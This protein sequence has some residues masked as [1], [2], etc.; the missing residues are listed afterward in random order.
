[1]NAGHNPPIWLKRRADG[2]YS[3]EHLEAGGTVVGA[4][5]RVCFEQGQLTLG[6][7]ETILV[8]TDG[9]TEAMNSAEEEFGEAR[10]L[11]LVQANLDRPVDELAEVIEETVMD[12]VEPVSLHD[13]L[14]LIIARGV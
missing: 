6:S 1:V 7:G 13:D 10:L 14:T 4:F 8:F 9:L 12:F 5:P 2:A 3:V 11:E